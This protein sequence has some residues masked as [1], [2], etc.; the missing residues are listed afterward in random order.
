MMNTPSHHRVHHGS[1][2]R[3]LDRN[4]AGVLILWDRLF[5]IFEPEGEKVIYG[6]TKIS[7]AITR[8]ASPFMSGSIFGMTCG[9]RKRGD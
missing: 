1:N 5:G 3:Y 2:Q 7:T 6:L 9:T 8:C 4:H